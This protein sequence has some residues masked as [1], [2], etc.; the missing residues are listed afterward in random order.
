VKLPAYLHTKPSG[1]E[2]LGDVPEHWEARRLK[3]VGTLRGG[4]GFPHEEQG[5][6]DEELPFYKVGDLK[7]S[8]DA[9]VMGKPEHTVSKE[10]AKKLRAA[11]IPSDSIVYAKIGAALLLNRRRITFVNC[12]IDNNMTAY[13]P[14]KRR[15]RTD[16][17]FY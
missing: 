6:E 7:A 4:A 11:I 9:R 13:L 14:E 1:V 2:W 15:I 12:C 17:A 10:T 16:W 5:L 3:D 8:V